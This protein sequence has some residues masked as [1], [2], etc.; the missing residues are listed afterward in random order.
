MPDAA[1]EGAVET[2]RGRMSEDL[3][4]EVLEF[5]SR[6]GA[7]EGRAAR[8]RLPEV[9][10][11]LRSGDGEIAGVNSVYPAVVPLIRRPFW[12]CRSFLTNASATPEMFNAAMATLAEEFERTGEGP[13]GLC[14]PIADR[15]EMERRPEPVWPETGLMFAGYTPEDTQ[16]RI[17]YFDE[18][19][20]GPGLP[21]SPTM[22]E[23]RDRDYTLP[24]RYRIVPLAESDAAPEDVIALWAREGAMTE[25]E[26]RRR[27]DEVIVVVVDRDE[28]PIGVSSAY[29]QPNE[30][31]RM[32]LWHTRVFV[33]RAHRGLNLA[34]RL[35]WAG[36]DLLDERF[37]GGEDTR[38]QGML[39]EV[40]NVGLRRYY[41]FALWEP[42]DFT[43]IGENQRGDH[44]RVHYFPGARVPVPT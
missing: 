31:L 39:F 11:L 22:A 20:I 33:A 4:A 29:L 10:C 21:D 15:A 17:R 35:A 14:L 3:G 26:A 16:L 1:F 19:V 18:A 41:N 44:V 32:D 8:D 30:Q 38:G 7:L 34:I 24:D 2:V 36:R 5:W 40:E 13:L 43:F 25:S 28:G 27:V 42:T 23:A 37:A 9:V 12:I 6:H